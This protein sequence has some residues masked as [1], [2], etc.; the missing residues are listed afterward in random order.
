MSE[1][2]TLTIVVD[3]QNKATAQ[4]KQV[5][6]SA[7][8]AGSSFGKMAGAMALGNFAA[9]AATQVLSK[10]STV[11]HNVFDEANQQQAVIAQFNNALKQTHAASG[12]ST[13]GLQKLAE[14]IEANSTFTKLNVEQAEK[15]ALTYTKVGKDTFPGVIQAAAD[16]STRM[17]MD[18]PSA[19]KILSVALSDPEKAFGRLKK[20]GVV[21]DEQQ[22]QNIKTLQK[23]GKFSEAQKAEL[24]A[25]AAVMGGSAKAATETFGGAVKRLSNEAMT[26]LVNET[27]HVINALNDLTKFLMAHKAVLAAVAGAVLGLAVAIGVALAPAIFAG[28]AAFAAMALA[29]LPFILIGAA[30]GAVAY[31][32]ITH[33]KTLKQWFNDFWGWI[34]AVF[35]DIVGFISGHWN[36]LLGIILGPIGIVIAHWSQLRSF[37]AGLIDDIVGF[38]ATLPSRAIAAIGNIGQRVGNDIKNAL[39]AIHIPGFASGVTNFSGGLAVVGEQGPEL[40]NLPSGSSVIPNNKI[41]SVAGAGSSITIHNTNYFTRDTDP[42]AFARRQ[43]FELARR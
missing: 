31:E 25:V 34:K 14:H 16:L 24:D 2:A 30:I 13:D 43:A 38:F 20:A 9:N 36:L 28:A 35:S 42:L 5:R 4:L 12:Q 37:F 29:A 33:W 11:L 7:D 18:M 1:V 39:H 15:M 41:G 10:V 23:S 40:V 3:A 21:L 22:Q 17:G 19:T 32:I 26:A 27:T 8:D 6:D